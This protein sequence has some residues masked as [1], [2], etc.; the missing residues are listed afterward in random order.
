MTWEFIKR[1]EKKT[2]EWFN[3]KVRK[4]ESDFTD[5]QGFLNWD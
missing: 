1:D 3:S 2:R 4:G 5:Y